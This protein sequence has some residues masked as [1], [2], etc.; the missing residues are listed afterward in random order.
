MKLLYFQ[1]FYPMDKKDGIP[2]PVMG[3]ISVALLL[4][5]AP[6]SAL[7]RHIESLLCISVFPGVLSSEQ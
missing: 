5:I 7:S 6:S 1:V 2:A 4:G 3:T